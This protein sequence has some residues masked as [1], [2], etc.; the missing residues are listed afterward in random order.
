[1]RKKLQETTADFSATDALDKPVATMHPVI[2]LTAKNMQV[3][4]WEPWLLII[5]N[6]LL[7][8]VRELH[9]QHPPARD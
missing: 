4:F 6:C 5:V 7:G 1:M 3:G 9:L 2:M 8:R